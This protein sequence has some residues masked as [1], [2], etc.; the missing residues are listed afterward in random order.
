[1]AGENS[2]ENDVKALLQRCA[3]S[4]LS[5]VSQIGRSTQTNTQTTSNGRSDAN[6]STN[7][8]GARG[9]GSSS[10]SNS[11]TVSTLRPRETAIAEHRRLFNF[12]P[13]TARNSVLNL[14]GNAKKKRKMSD[15]PLWTTY[16]CACHPQT[17]N[18]CLF[19]ESRTS[20]IWYWRK[21][22]LLSPY[23]TFEE[24]MYREFPNLREGGRFE[25]LRSSGKFLQAIPIPS[26]GYSVDYLK[27]V[28]AQAKCYVRP[29]QMDLNL[30]REE[31]CV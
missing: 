25:V 17:G 22:N 13:S 8:S 4:L 19:R 11:A 27:S 6:V 2:N 26:G 7:F 14:R 12:Q 30:H 10:A 18:T 29:L 28:L 31:V 20:F 16:L 15:K 9:A 21:E 23:E 24:T 3:D 1:M 5:A